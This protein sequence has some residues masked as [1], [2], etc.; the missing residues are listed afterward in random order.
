MTSQPS[1]FAAAAVSPSVQEDN[2]NQDLELYSPPPSSMTLV[3]A[4]FLLGSPLFT[5]TVFNKVFLLPKDYLENWLIWAYHQPVP[6]KE[7]RRQ[8]LALRKAAEGLALK[9]PKLNDP[10]HDPGPID[11]SPL[12]DDHFPL[13]LRE[14][15]VVW[16]GTQ[17]NENVTLACAVPERFYEV[18]FVS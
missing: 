8:Q 16:D 5:I 1:S 17:A 14:N 7:T 6:P 10:Y 4:L 3:A 13:V 9:V 18:G 15:V 2:A 11:S 12:S